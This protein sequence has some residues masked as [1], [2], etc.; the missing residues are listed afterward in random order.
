MINFHQLELNGYMELNEITVAEIL[1]LLKQQYFKMKVTE[2]LLLPNKLNSN[3][4]ITLSKIYGVNP[5]PYHT[6]GA[7]NISPPKYIILENLSKVDTLTNTIICPFD[8]K[9]LFKEKPSLKD[10]LFIILNGRNSFY[11]TI[12]TERNNGLNFIRW[13]PLIMKSISNIPFDINNIIN[14]NL[15][16]K[17]NWNV[18]KV[19]IVDNWRC[20][21]AR[22]K[23]DLI[24]MKHRLIKRY[25]V[26][27]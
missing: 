18:G 13:N 5:F 14:D 15:I 9:L 23:L 22:S 16:T 21:H 7:N 8:L 3:Y 6:D 17:I 27:I 19:V 25:S 24:S 12:L 26:F 10:E 2:H 11:S 1:I 4:A 20:V